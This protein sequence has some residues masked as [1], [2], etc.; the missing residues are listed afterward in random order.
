MTALEFPESE[1]PFE[2]LIANNPK[3][4]D[5]LSAMAYYPVTAIGI[6]LGR[7]FDEVVYMLG[8]I[9]ALVTSLGIQRI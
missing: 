6:T 7:P 9:L 3:F 1:S 4:I 8:S 5:D 2:R